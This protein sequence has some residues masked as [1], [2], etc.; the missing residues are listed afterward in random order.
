MSHQIRLHWFE[1]QVSLAEA[2]QMHTICMNGVI[3]AMR[4][5]DLKM[6][7][8]FRLKEHA[9]ATV[10]SYKKH[11]YSWGNDPNDWVFMPE[12]TDDITD[13]CWEAQRILNQHGVAGC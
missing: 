4:E 12:D 7:Q 10:I 5:N 1:K 6:Y 11:P 2:T 13:I 3:A 9:Y 8:I